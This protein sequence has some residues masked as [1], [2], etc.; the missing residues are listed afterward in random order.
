MPIS[1]ASAMPVSKS[2]AAAVTLI[3]CI[4]Q[5]LPKSDFVACF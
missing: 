5:L 2:H 3:L 4:I 1:L